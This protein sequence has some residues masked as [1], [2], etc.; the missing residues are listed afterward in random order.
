LKKVRIIVRLK[1]GVL[2]PQG[3]TVHHALG[4]LGFEEVADVRIGKYIEVALDEVP[5]GESLDARIRAMC[6]KLL[7]NPVI[8]DYEVVGA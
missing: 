2:D 6:D 5:A 4:S 8:E 7:V 3:K 1:E